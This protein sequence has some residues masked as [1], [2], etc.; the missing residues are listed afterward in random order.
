MV[1]TTATMDALA[2][3]PSATKAKDCKATSMAGRLRSLATA[4]RAGE[5]QYEFC[6]G[7]RDNGWFGGLFGGRGSEPKTAPDT[8]IVGELQA[9]LGPRGYSVSCKKRYMN[10]VN[11]TYWD[12]VITW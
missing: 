4:V 1:D 8:S 11:S 3:L 9:I 2:T 12:C 6:M 7:C 5:D 10:E